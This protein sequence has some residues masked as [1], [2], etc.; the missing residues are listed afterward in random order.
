MKLKK[1]IQIQFSENVGSIDLDMNYGSSSGTW[2]SGE[3]FLE[4]LDGRGGMGQMRHR[5]P[6]AFGLI[7]AHTIEQ[8]LKFAVEKSGIEC[9]GAIC[10][11]RHCFKTSNTYTLMQKRE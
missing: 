7:V 2:L 3:I 8:V 5:L 11:K 6:R 4:F 9:N 1:H 10:G